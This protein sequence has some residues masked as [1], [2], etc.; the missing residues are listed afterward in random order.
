[1]PGS[2]TIRKLDNLGTSSKTKGEKAWLIKGKS[3]NIK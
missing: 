2:S 1:M 3:D